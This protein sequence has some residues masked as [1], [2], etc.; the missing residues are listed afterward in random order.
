MTGWKPPLWCG[1]VPPRSGSQK[2]TG[3]SL[4]GLSAKSHPSRLAT[5][6]N[7]KT[8][9]KQRG[10]MKRHCDFG[11]IHIS[12][13]LLEREHCGHNGSEND[14]QFMVCDRDPNMVCTPTGMGRSFL[15]LWQYRPYHHWKFALN[16]TFLSGTSPSNRCFTSPFSFFF[17]H[18]RREIP[19]SV[20]V[21]L[22]RTLPKSLE[23][24][25]CSAMLIF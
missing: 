1:D 4:T 15:I 14:I 18:D 13:P 22:L 6:N 2:R 11:M 3:A 19:P 5:Y 9:K 24:M 21:L 20:G 25:W 7:E 17:P 8:T 23:R 10:S 12:P 16:P